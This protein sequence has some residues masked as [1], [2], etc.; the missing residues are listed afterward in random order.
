MVKPP[1]PA[2]PAVWF[3]DTSALLTLAVDDGLR[4][5]IK[6]EIEPQ[7]HILLDVVCDELERLADEG[8]PNV[9]SLAATALGQLDWLGAVLDTND[10]V[11]PGRVQEIQDLVRGG[12]P[13]KNP[14][15]HWAESV[16]MALAERMQSGIPYFLC[17]DYS[18]RVES[19]HSGCLPFSVHK[20]LFHMVRAGRLTADRA[21]GFADAVMRAGRGSDYTAE[22]FTSGR[23]GRVGRP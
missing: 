12:R 22:E 23:L 19:R 1:A 9:K 11:A 2:K 17:E 3:I 20:L 10:K 8:P 15:E 7:H 14:F 16:T 21:V 13:L 18:A 4:D 5:V 6:V